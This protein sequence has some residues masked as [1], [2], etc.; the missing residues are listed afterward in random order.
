MKTKILIKGKKG[1][2]ETAKEVL[3]AFELLPIENMVKT[4]I[5]EGDSLTEDFSALLSEK[6]TKGMHVPFPEGTETLESPLSASK[7]LL[8]DGISSDKAEELGRMQ[9][10]WIFI[11]LSTKLFRNYESELNELKDQIS[12]LTQYSKEKWDV[13]KN[14]W[15]KVQT[16]IN[17]KN[18]FREHSNTLKNQTNVL[19][20]QL[21]KL[22]SA[23]DAVFE[24]S[25]KE[26]YDK[27]M[28]KLITLEE[29]TKQN[30]NLNKIFGDLKSLQLELKMLN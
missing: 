18:L 7:S 15:A 6:W 17:E 11:V 28:L 16:Q 29:S 30:E 9:T 19:F 14:F 13:M 3:C 1:S 20:A 2:E 26:I 23:Q 4:W 22:R 27:L 25:A 8:P 10:E 12:T 24:T 5:F 21:K